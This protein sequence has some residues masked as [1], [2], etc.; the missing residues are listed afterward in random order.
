MKTGCNLIDFDVFFFLDTIIVIYKFTELWM[1]FEENC[2]KNN[3]KNLIF[4]LIIDF[5]RWNNIFWCDLYIYR[6]Y[7]DRSELDISDE[8]VRIK[9]FLT[10]RGYDKKKIW[11]LPK[12]LRCR[13]AHSFQTIKVFPNYH[14]DSFQTIKDIDLKL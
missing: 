9:S 1:Y 2:K 4:H 3:L 8:T 11:K 6:M 7:S 13:K 14:Y 5:Y 10:V 12:L